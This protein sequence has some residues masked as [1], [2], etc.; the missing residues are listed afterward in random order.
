[1]YALAVNGSPRKEGN[2]GLDHRFGQRRVSAEAI[3]VTC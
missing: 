1:M 2:T 3:S